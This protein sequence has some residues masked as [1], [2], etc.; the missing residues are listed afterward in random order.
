M[1]V[2]QRTDKIDIAE[3]QA[4]LAS[5]VAQFA[6]RTDEQERNSRRAW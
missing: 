1:S 6:P 2:R 3:A 4:E 5:A